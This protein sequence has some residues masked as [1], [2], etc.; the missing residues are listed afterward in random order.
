MDVILERQEAARG[1]AYRRRRASGRLALLGLAGFSMAP[2]VPFGWVPFVL[3]VA[4]MSRAAW[5]WMIAAGDAFEGD[6][7]VREVLTETDQR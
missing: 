7:D 2:F 5:V 3:G 6:L 4:V 1:R